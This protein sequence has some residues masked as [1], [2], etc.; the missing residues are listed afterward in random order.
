V[1]AKG[2][3]APADL[4]SSLMWFQMLWIPVCIVKP[5]SIRRYAGAIEQLAKTDKI[6]AAVIAEF[7]AVIQPRPT[8]ARS[9]KLIL[10]KDL[11]VRRRQVME[12]RT[13]ELNRLQI[14]GNSIAPS[15]KRLLNYLDKEVTRLEKALDEQ[16]Q[17]ENEWAEKKACY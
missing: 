2:H 8:V 5:L 13:Q 6:D 11:L 15:C 3:I 12:M 4:S 9:K 17:A 7:A 1:P 10:I 14:M 16:V